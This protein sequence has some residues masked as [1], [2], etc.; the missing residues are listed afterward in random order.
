MCTHIRHHLDQHKIS[1]PKNH[2]FRAKHST[3]SQLLLTTH[4]MLK[5]LDAGKQLDVAIS[6]LSKAFD[7]VPHQQLLAKL[8]HYGVSGNVLNWVKSFLVKRTQSV[9][10]EGARSR[11]EAVPS[12]VPQVT[13]LG[14]LLFILYIND[15]P[16]QVH[17]DTRCRLFADDCLVYHAIHSEKDQVILQQDLRNLEH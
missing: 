13:V 11:E 10:V 2:S 17:Q 9:V 16:S 12:G 1:G 7:T 5:F 15:L 4:D 3:E 14:P 8:D 6:D